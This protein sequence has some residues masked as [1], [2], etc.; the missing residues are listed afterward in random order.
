MSNYNLQLFTRAEV[1]SLIVRHRQTNRNRLIPAFPG[2]AKAYFPEYDA[3]EY[4]YFGTRICRID[5]LGGVF[6]YE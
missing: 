5:S 4:T 3:T 1:V 6:V 2:L